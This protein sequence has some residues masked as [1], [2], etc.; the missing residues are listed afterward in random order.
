M[1]ITKGRDRAVVPSKQDGAGK[2]EAFLTEARTGRRA[3]PRETGI[4]SALNKFIPWLFAVVAASAFLVGA[5]LFF[6][7]VQGDKVTEV[8]SWEVVHPTR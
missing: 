3:R 7:S 4:D 5:A 8:L 6:L 1:S 2:L